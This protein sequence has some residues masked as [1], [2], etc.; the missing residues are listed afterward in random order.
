M[1]HSVTWDCLNTVKFHFATRD[2]H[3]TTRGARQPHE[4][5]LTHLAWKI[6]TFRGR[7]WH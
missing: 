5:T 7:V 2:Q 3:A 1:L 6:S 4:Q